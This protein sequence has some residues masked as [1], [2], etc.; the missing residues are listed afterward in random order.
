MNQM[1]EVVLS[2]LEVCFGGGFE[3]GE[4]MSLK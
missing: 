1:K 4:W 2:L 3:L